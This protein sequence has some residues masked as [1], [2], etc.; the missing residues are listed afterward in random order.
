[1][2]TKT[3]MLAAATSLSLALSLPA[4]AAAGHAYQPTV[5][6]DA[7]YQYQPSMGGDAGYAYQPA[8]GGDAGYE[9]SPR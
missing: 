8:V 7:G 4:F 6:G 5:G 3:F 2:M 1:M 9:Y